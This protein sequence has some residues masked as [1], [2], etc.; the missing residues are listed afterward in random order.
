MKLL[1]KISLMVLVV[2]AV[3]MFAS[4]GY[5]YRRG[6]VHYGVRVYYG[7][8]WYYGGPVWRPY[9]LAGPGTYPYPYYRGGFGY[10]SRKGVTGSYGLQGDWS[11]Q[12]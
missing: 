3:L 9:P 1:Y 12:H 10:G 11:G 2:I 8:P 6:R 5:S 4:P 7:T